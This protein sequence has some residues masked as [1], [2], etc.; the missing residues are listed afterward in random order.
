MTIAFGS[1]SSAVQAGISSVLYRAPDTLAAGDLILWCVANKYPTNGPNAPTGLSL[2]VQAQ[3]GAGSAGADSGNVYGTVFSK[4]SDGTEDAAT[5]T[6]SVPSGNSVTS[7]SVS[8][9]RTAGTGWGIV[10][11]YGAQ[12]TAAD[13]WSVASAATM[14]LA[15]GDK[16]V[17]V[18]AQ[19][20]DG[21]ITHANYALSAPGIGFGALVPRHG[22]SAAIG[23]TNGDDCAMRVLEADVTSGSGTGT[24]SLSF[25]LTGSAGSSAG[26]V[27]FIRLRETGAASALTG[28]ASGTGTASGTMTHMVPFVPATITNWPDALRPASVDWGLLVPQAVGRSVFNGTA[29]VT[30]LGAPCWAFTIDTGALR[31]S[32]LP[33]WEA[34]IDLLQGGTG[35][36]R[37]WDWRREA[38][39][40]V[41]TGTPLV[42][43]AGAGASLQ[44]K[45]WTPNVAGIL[46]AGSYFSV[47]G[48][49]KRLVADASSNASGHAT[50]YF[51]PPLRNQAAVDQPL[52][53]VKPTAVFMLTDER[54][55][56]AQ[57]GARFPGRS[58]SFM[59]DLR[60]S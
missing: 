59:E 49:L 44:T 56:W 27:L 19:N 60:Y 5:E 42:R 23:T 17:I 51:K 20:G 35:R 10:S 53:L 34:L 11:S 1:A 47:N 40:G 28:A 46:L 54:V 57:E 16:I 14:N 50:L 3:G 37:C 55:S 38:P 26:V 58:L 39:L 24:L 13:S 52:T 29:Q 30:T 45:G 9:T 25:D 41:A 6:V 4:V 21:D 43:V 7:R 18:I 12:N 2:L 31:R 48:E 33:Q 8:Y 32:E 15:A 36:L 22:N